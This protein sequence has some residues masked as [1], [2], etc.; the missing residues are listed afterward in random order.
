MLLSAADTTFTHTH[1]HLQLC[2]SW[3]FRPCQAHRRVC[4]ISFVI[5][6][7]SSEWCQ[8]EESQDRGG[9]DRVVHSVSNNRHL[10]VCFCV[11]LPPNISACTFFLRMTGEPI[12]Q[13]YGNWNGRIFW[14]KCSQ[15]DS[16][17]KK[18][19]LFNLHSMPYVVRQGNTWKQMIL[20]RPHRLHHLPAA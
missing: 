13:I 5:V 3:P 12:S 14:G 15:F 7:S 2:S 6:M 4:G 17:A 9:L 16:A 10:E 18:V 1:T 11:T 8:H 19:T 20:S